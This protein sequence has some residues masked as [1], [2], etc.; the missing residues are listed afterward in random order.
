MNDKVVYRHL[1]PCGEV[2]Y[3]GIGSV[4]RAYDIHSRNKHWNHTVNKYGYE[5]QMRRKVKILGIK[6]LKLV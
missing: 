1:K 5:V 4:R 2:F 6:V 3:I